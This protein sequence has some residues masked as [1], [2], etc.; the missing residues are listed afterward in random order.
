MVFSPQRSVNFPFHMQQG[1]MGN[2]FRPF[3]QLQ[4]RNF[5]NAPF[6][7]G[8]FSRGNFSGMQQ[9]ATKGGKLKNLLSLLQP[10]SG[11]ST[12]AG[13]GVSKGIGGLSGALDNM[14]QVI[15]VVQN[16]APIVKEYGPMV[17]NLPAMFRMMK[18]FKSLDDTEDDTDEE[19]KEETEENKKD[20]SELPKSDQTELE[21][22]K[23][24]EPSIIED[25]Q[26]KGKSVPKLF[27]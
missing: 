1:N 10:Q 9:A 11:A 12:G 24:N 26:Q 22:E 14:Q 18:A 17:K 7:A 25:E 2:N 15:N 3:Q 13:G 27:I 5:Q 21:S 4:P 20:E 19:E 8:P 6:Q 16:A 23:A